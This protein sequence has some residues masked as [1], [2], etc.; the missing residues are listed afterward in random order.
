MALDAALEYLLTSEKLPHKERE[1]IQRFTIYNTNYIIA[2]HCRWAPT[3]F[4]MRDEIFQD[5]GWYRSFKA[6]QT[7]TS[8]SRRSRLLRRGERTPAPSACSK[9][10]DGSDNNIASGIQIR[11]ESQAAM[12]TREYF[13]GTGTALAAAGAAG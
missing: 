13:P 10:G 6:R 1:G 4:R 12:R 11:I 3:I 8:L 9:R 2:L 7:W 5:I